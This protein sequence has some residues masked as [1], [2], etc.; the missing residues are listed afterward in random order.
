MRALLHDRRHVTLAIAGIA[1]I[2]LVLRLLAARGGLWLDEA[3]SAVYAA[4]ARTPLGV[5]IS[6]NHDNNHHLNSLWLQAIGLSAPPLLARA[7]SIIAGT[8]CIFVAAAIGA[9]RGTAAALIAAALFA[10]SPV[11]VHYGAEARGYATMTLAFLAAIL[12][13]DRWLDDPGEPP[14]RLA[15]GALALFGLLSQLTMV[16]GLV[17]IGG[18]ALGRLFAAGWRRKAIDRAFDLMIPALVATLLVF[19]LVFGAAAASKTGLQV[20]SYEDFTFP[21]FL[22]ALEEL[23]TTSFG[24]PLPGGRAAALVMVA[25]PLAALLAPSL[26]PRIGFYLLAIIGFPLMTALLQMPNT[27]YSRYYLVS[28]VAMLLLAADWLGHAL[29]GSRV[30]RTA[31][32]IICSLLLAACLIRDIRQIE[33][34]HADPALPVEAMRRAAPGGT[35]ILLDNIRSHAVLQAAAASAHYPLVI[36]EACPAAPF[37]LLDATR[38]RAFPDTVRRCGARYRAVITRRTRDLPG[39]DWRLYRRETPGT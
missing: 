12:V 27:H 24:T 20:G 7:P 29:T 25:V 39:M 28:G 22:E 13:V 15:L 17:A 33:N 26:R 23:V 34:A 4:Q 9:R 37:F 1:A 14:P 19:T 16:F 31:A 10:V 32:A 35:A 5:F 2:G 36:R 6:I 38:P 8:A 21:G 11:L 18:W 30:A 3:W